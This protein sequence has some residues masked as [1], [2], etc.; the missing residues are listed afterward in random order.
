MYLCPLLLYFLK[1][2]ALTVYFYFR[3]FED[4]LALFLTLENVISATS[5][6][7]IIPKM[8]NPLTAIK[9]WLHIISWRNLL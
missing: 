8:F 2:L 1:F 7:S 3:H 6:S 4:T 9:V 5:R